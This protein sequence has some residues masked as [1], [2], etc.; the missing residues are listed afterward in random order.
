MASANWGSRLHVRRVVIS[1]VS[2]RA[3][4]PSAI[5]EL[6][7]ITSQPEQRFNR[8]FTE[9]ILKQNVRKSLS[10]S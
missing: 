1:C 7:A 3:F 2:Y 8:T 6:T 4:F 10:R 5:V 9:T